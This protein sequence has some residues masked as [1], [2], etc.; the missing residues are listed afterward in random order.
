M[1]VKLAH[2]LKYQYLIG[3]G[4]R[5]EAKE[6]LSIVVRLLGNKELSD[7]L[8]A[9]NID[10]V[11]VK[12]NQ[13]FPHHATR[14]ILTE[15]KS[16]SL[17]AEAIKSV[18]DSV[19]FISKKQIYMK[20]SSDSSAGQ[21]DEVASITTDT[22][23]QMAVHSLEEASRTPVTPL[24]DYEFASTKIT[25]KIDINTFV[26][27]IRDF[28][29]S[30]EEG[31][32]DRFIVTYISTNR[33][34]GV[35]TKEIVLALLLNTATVLKEVDVIECIL[36][37][38]IGSYDILAIA[39]STGYSPFVSALCLDNDTIL[40]K[41]QTYIALHSNISKVPCDPDVL[42][43]LEAIVHRPNFGINRREI[44]DNLLHLYDVESIS[45]IDKLIDDLEV[46]IIGED[47]LASQ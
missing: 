27:D 9:D 34:Q 46:E 25:A 12:L 19:E 32:V 37:Q 22:E 31:S 13:I 20:H 16:I 30:I 36:H 35:T 24:M 14:Q 40:K 6:S 4:R 21:S 39:D 45:S 5:E 17:S 41:F 28:K 10:E 44:Y 11:V 23:P 26:D 43:N 8:S 38:D 3:Q 29:K 18:P 33:A 42:I 2:M 47:A 15:N 1:C 7:Q